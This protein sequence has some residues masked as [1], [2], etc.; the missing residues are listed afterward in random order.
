MGKKERKER[1][2]VNIVRLSLEVSV[3]WCDGIGSSAAFE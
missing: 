1:G 2:K 3:V